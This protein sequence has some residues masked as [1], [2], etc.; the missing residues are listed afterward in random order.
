VVTAEELPV[1]VIGDRK[2]RTAAISGCHAEI[3]TSHRRGAPRSTKSAVMKVAGAILQ[4]ARRAAADQVAHDEPEIEAA[5]M[6]QQALEDIRVA[7]QM[8]AT[9]PTRVVEM[10]EGAFDPRAPLTHQ[11]TAARATNPPPIGIYRAQVRGLPGPLAATA[12]RLRDV[13]P[14]AYGLTSIIV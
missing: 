13:R 11:A 6:N 7:A 1:V 8:R 14:E 4:P 5:R 9:H 12:V 2:Q 3:A 10:R